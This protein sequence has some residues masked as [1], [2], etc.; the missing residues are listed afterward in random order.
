M[1]KA[2]A[3]ARVFKKSS[4]LGGFNLF[5]KNTFDGNQ[6]Q[7]SFKKIENDTEFLERNLY[8]MGQSIP[9]WTK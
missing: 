9:E 5:W 6:F 2:K 1:Q 7:I 4:Q 3:F 8:S